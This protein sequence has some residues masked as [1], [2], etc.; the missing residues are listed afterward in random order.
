[1]LDRASTFALRHPFRFIVGV[2][3]SFQANRGL[4]LAGAVAYYALLSLIPVL[5]LVIA[6]LGYVVGSSEGD[7][8]RAVL[9]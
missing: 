4:L 5:F 2:L 3:R 8:F 1:M 9:Q 6:I 7:T